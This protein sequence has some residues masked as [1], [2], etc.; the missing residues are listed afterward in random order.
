MGGFRIEVTLKARSLEDATA[1]VATLPFMD[2]NW[3]TDQV[4]HPEYKVDIMVTSK[5]GVLANAGWVHQRAVDVGM[6]L[7]RNQDRAAVDQLQAVVDMLAGFGWNAGQGTRRTVGMSTDAWWT[8]VADGGQEVDAGG[9][10]GILNHLRQ[11]YVT[12]EQVKSLLE[13]LKSKSERGIVPCKVD[14]GVD[15]HRYHIAGWTP[16]KLSMDLTAV[17]TT[18]LR[19]RHSSGLLSG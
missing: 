4:N 8:N 11:T 13:M 3:W 16:F 1:K 19:Q 2:I 7:G 10:L 12:K 14:N 17:S 5:A 18:W 15:R 9:Q 6:L